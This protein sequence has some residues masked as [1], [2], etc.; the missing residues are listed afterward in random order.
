LNS[1]VTA[2]FRFLIGSSLNVMKLAILRVSSH[3]IALREY[4]RRGLVSEAVRLSPRSK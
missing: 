3:V 4:R 1:A 2:G